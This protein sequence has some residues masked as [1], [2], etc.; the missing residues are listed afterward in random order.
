MTQELSE[1]VIAFRTAMSVVKS[2]LVSGIICAADYTEIES[3]LTKYY[4]LS[5]STIFR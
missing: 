2:M 1:K 5:S 3:E 4:G